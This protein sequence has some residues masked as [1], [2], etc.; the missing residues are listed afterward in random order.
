MINN[1]AEML[2][3]EPI[4]IVDVNSIDYFLNRDYS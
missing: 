2:F 3:Q 4:L 1:A